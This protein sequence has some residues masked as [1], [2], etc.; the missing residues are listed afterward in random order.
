VLIVDDEASIRFGIRDYLEQRGFV[1]SEAA[2]CRSAREVFR[3]ARPDV[4]LLDYLLPD[5]NALD[6]LAS[7]RESDPFVSLLILTAHGTIDLAVRA[8]KE[9][10]EQF[11]TKPVE[12][13]A[14]ALMIERLVE[15]RRDRRKQIAGASRSAREALDPFL[16][17][18]TVIRH[19]A[20]EAAR[21]AR[22]ECPVLVLGETGSGKGLL[23]GWLHGHSPR[24][25]EAFVDLN[26]ASLSREFL[27]S[28]LF[29]HEKGA[30]TGA[31]SSKPG[32]LEVAQHGTLFLDEIGDLD[33]AVQPKLLKALEDKRFR[34]LGE[35]RDRHADVRLIAATH[36]DLDLLVQE[37]KFRQD[38]YYRISIVPLVVPALRERAEDI[39]AIAAELLART[40]IRR[41]TVPEL[42]PAAEHALREYSWP[43]NIRELRNVLERAVLLDADG[44]I[45]REDL[46]FGPSTAPITSDS[47]LTLSEL[48][49]QHIERVLRAEQGRVDRA[50]QRLGLPRSSLY[51]KLKRYGLDASKS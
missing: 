36:Q 10:A 20:E 41:G 3:A 14:L 23:T 19:L 21:V 7:L 43:G 4:A 35:V 42:T 18:S 1:V 34:R 24:A 31:T 29:G 15:N 44:R 33:P 13:E 5:G 39:L 8:V 46:R 48:E 2:D 37:K 6:L 49:R 25:N 27:E 9:G 11:L 12:L 30:F 50:A 45:D 17:Q 28:E 16:G 38:L 40:A 22:A 32:L 51:A 47:D 26:C